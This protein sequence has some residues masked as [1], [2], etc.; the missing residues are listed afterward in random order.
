MENKEFPEEQLLREDPSFEED[1]L[2]DEDLLLMDGVEP[3]AEPIPEEAE[4]ISGQ[5]ASPA[6]EPA[7]SDEA[8]QAFMMMNAVPREEETVIA[9]DPEPAPADSEHV[10][11]E[12]EP[13]SADPEPA[14]EVGMP[15]LEPVMSDPLPEEDPLAPECDADPDD[16]ERELAEAEALIAGKAL[17]DRFRD[18]EHGT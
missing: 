9:E 8:F 7:M 2:P 15:A 11:P 10:M 17:D 5:E 4:E 12:A 6:E 14:A 13:V 16:L 18:M 3:P 1:A